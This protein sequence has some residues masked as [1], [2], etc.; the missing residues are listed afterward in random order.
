M[1]VLLHGQEPDAPSA[2]FLI[3]SP[4]NFLDEAM[5]TG[6]FRNKNSVPSRDCNRKD[7][8]TENFG[9]AAT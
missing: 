4:L 3:P 7:A 2:F 8:L 9:V 1:P 6:T 5:F